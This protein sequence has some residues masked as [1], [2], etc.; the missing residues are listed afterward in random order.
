MM[1][2]E[3]RALAA[4]PLVGNG[5]KDELPA[6][7]LVD[8]VSA[9]GY[10][11][12]GSVARRED[13]DVTRQTTA[14]DRYCTLRG[15]ELVGL[16]LDVEPRKPRRAGCPSLLHAVERLR[17]GDARGLVVA[18]L[19]RLCPSVAEL[20]GVLEALD[21]AG[22]R[23]VSLDPEI[24]TGT[25]IGH[26]IAHA[27]VSVSAWERSRRA[28]MTAAARSKVAIASAIRPEL[29][30]RII[31]MRDAGMT[32]QSIADDLN[33]EGV[34]TLRGGAKWRPSSVQSALGY[35]RPSPWPVSTAVRGPG[36]AGAPSRGRSCSPPRTS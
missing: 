15:W 8:H 34:P 14:I 33:E 19:R 21:Q 4:P 26:A 28:D 20:G 24:D 29:R 13:S 16:V 10:V 25:P 1:H 27:L 9:L 36:R 35:R 6:S 31:R 32:L 2:S 22:A 3:D 7:D 18:E 12:V 23:L 30:R 17:R 11:S 5:L